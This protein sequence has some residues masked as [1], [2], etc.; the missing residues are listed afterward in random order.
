MHYDLRAPGPAPAE[1]AKAGATRVT[2][3]E[4]HEHHTVMADPQGNEFS[5]E[6][7]QHSRQRTRPTRGIMRVIVV[8]LITM[9]G[10]R[11]CG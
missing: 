4:H 2:A 7:A 5:A 3:L 8:K 11:R 10:C 6:L 9:L 1:A